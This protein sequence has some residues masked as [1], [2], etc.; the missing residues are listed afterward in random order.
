MTWS[1]D[2]TKWFNAVMANRLEEIE[3]LIKS[4]E[5]INRF[6]NSH[7][8]ALM[9]AV[10]TCNPELIKL[11]LKYNPQMQIKNGI[12]F[13]A[14]TYAILQ[15]KDWGKFWSIEAPSSSPLEILRAAGGRY[16]GRD[17]VL[18]NDSN[19]LRSLIRNGSNV[20]LGLDS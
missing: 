14:I 15:A 3:C 9:I 11:L 13:S 2:G 17:A 7:S 6:C 5:N 8:T 12:L 16:E 18:L 4:G 10:R 19:Q 1:S 20:N